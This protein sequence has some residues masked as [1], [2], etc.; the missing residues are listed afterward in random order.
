MWL[1]LVLMLF[2]L[3]SPG[4]R[5]QDVFFDIAMDLGEDRYRILEDRLNNNNK[6]NNNFQADPFPDITYDVEA[7]SSGAPTGQGGDGFE[8]DSEVTD[9]SQLQV[10]VP[11][12][13]RLCK[14]VEKIISLDTY[15]EGLWMLAEGPAEVDAGPQE[16]DVGECKG[17]CLT[18]QQAGRKSC[19]AVITETVLLKHKGTGRT[20]KLR[21]IKECACVCDRIERCPEGYFW[22]AWHC[23][24]EPKVAPK[25]CKRHSLYKRLEQFG[26]SVDVGAC[27]GQCHWKG[28]PAVC[29][30][31]TFEEQTV[32]TAYGKE[33]V[34]R[35]ID[36]CGCSDCRVKPRYRMVKIDERT[37]KKVNVG[38]C[39]G[40]CGPDAWPEGQEDV[41]SY[42][43]STCAVAATRTIVFGAVRCAVCACAIGRCE[44]LRYRLLSCDDVLQCT[45][46][47]PLRGARG[48]LDFQ[49]ACQGWGKHGTPGIP[50]HWDSGTSQMGIGTAR[51]WGNTATEEVA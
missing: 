45:P 36:Q 39:G 5:A 13:M 40:G 18:T 47:P 38:Y 49:V 20:S 48:P 22:N 50:L 19:E 27:K 21:K 9:R 12:P 43:T 33:V 25:P 10:G 15:D 16:V 8:L 4:T 2:V 46:P 28:A 34:V 6:N 17:F 42:W 29:R 1:L 23:R 24:C 41:Q 11:V 31:L 35:A 51:G 44:G 32:G 7:S 14:R 37:V 3:D 30:A 26:A